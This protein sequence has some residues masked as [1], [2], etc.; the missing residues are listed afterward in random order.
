MNGLE[1]L[2]IAELAPM[3]RDRRISPV[4]LVK[5]SLSRVASLAEKYPAFIS[6]QED[7]S[8]RQAIIAETAIMSGDYLGPLHGIPIGVKDLYHTKDVV[9]TAGSRILTDFIPQEDA[10]VVRLLKEAGAI[11]IGKTNMHPFAYGPLGINPD[12]GTPANPWNIERIPGG[13]SSGSAVALALGIVPGATGTDTAGSIRI[14]AAL[15]GVVGIKPT[16]GLVSRHGVIPLA[17]SLD[18]A[19][20]MARSVEDCAILLQAMAGYDP[21]D[22]SS[23]EIAVPAYQN[24][25]RDSVKGLKAGIPRFEFFS[26]LQ[27]DVRS[28]IDQAAETLEQIGTKIIEVDVP[29]D[30]EALSI[31]L[32]I[33]GPEASAYHKT[34]VAERPEDYFV[35]VLRQL[36]SGMNVSAVDYIVALERRQQFAEA[37]IEAFQDIDFLLAPTVPVTAPRM[38]ERTIQVNG[39]DENTQNMLTLLNRPFNLSRMPSVS[40]PC[41][42]DNDGMPIGLQIV[43]KP[44]DEKLVLR[45]AFAY[46]QATDWHDKHPSVVV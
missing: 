26:K 27:P 31:L 17:S 22:S 11:V 19:G 35:P 14:P 34:W 30:D 15:C 29:G 4:E 44:F 10:T 43:G 45:V 13:S 21:R 16:Y 6:V 23:I 5:L 40:V 2:T 37:Y 28:A 39:V 46:E 41:G 1:F 3:V 25:L 42:F 8:L 24:A 36:E 32:G 33:L 7:A 9:T 20:P 18:H 38:G 12:F